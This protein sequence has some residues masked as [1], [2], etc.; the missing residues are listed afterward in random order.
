MAAVFV[1]SPIRGTRC[2]SSRWVTDPNPEVPEGLDDRAGE[3]ASLNH[4]DLFSL[5]EM[6]LPAERM[7]MILGTD[8]AGIGED[9]NEGG[10]AQRRHREPRVDRRRDPR[11]KRTLFSELH[12]GTFAEKVAV[13]SGTCCPS[14]LT[15]LRRG[16]LPAHGLADR[17]PDAVREVGPPP[18]PDRAGAGRQRRRGDGADRARPR[19]GYRMW[20][21]GRSEEKRAQPR[22]S[23]ARTR[24]SR[25]ARACPRGWTASWRP[26][27][28]PPGRTASSRSS[29]AVWWSPRV[30]RRAS[31]RARSSTGSSSPSCR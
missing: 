2:P 27:A 22:S 31:T 8:A 3:A 15:V 19:A 21:T 17:L 4:H 1:S 13:P 11:P 29:P 25:P 5:R 16:R 30:R 6:G 24:R 20:V 28:R 23:W 10:R 9:G 7:P 12:Q 26:S 18:G 14:R